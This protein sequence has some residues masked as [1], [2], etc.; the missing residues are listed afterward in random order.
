MAG[1]DVATRDM[2]LK[3]SPKPFVVS[4]AP[5]D[6]AVA[7]LPLQRMGEGH[8]MLVHVVEVQTGCRIDMD[9]DS[10]EA[11]FNS[12]RW[13]GMPA[14]LGVKSEL[15]AGTKVQIAVV[16]VPNSNNTYDV[17]KHLRFPGRVKTTL[18]QRL[19]HGTAHVITHTHPRTGMKEFQ[20][21]FNG[22]GSLLFS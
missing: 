11:A 22:L 4:G 8:T 15:P 3:E 7:N 1:D 10:L 20:K 9:A 12:D 6:I 14:P 5:G 16:P 17:V 19:L 21:A 18:I 13:K 2:I